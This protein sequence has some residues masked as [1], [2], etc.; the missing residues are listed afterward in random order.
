MIMLSRTHALLMSDA[1][2]KFETEKEELKKAYYE[3]IKSLEQHI[4]DL[5][6]L[7]F[8]P[9]SA[10]DIPLVHLEADAVISQRDEVM[11]VSQEE[12]AK[13]DFIL[14]ERDRIFSGS[15]EDQIEQ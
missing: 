12:A 11:E 7:V 13:Q 8:S 4:E 2:K 3:H 5:K 1:F 10:K 6:A 14:R 15:Y 9:T